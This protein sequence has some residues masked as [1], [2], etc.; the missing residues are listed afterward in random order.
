MKRVLLIILVFA[1][2]V[3][4]LGLLVACDDAPDEPA[5]PPADAPPPADVVADDLYIAILSKGFQ[6]QFWQAVYQGAQDAAAHYGVSIFF[7]GPE[8]EADIH[9]QVE[10]FNQQLALNPDG[11][12]LAALATDS[13]EAQL[14]DAFD[15]GI[16]VVGFDSGVPDA[17]PGQ[18]LATASTNNINA[19]AIGAD[20][21]FPEI[22]AQLAAATT[23]SPALIIILSQDVTSE[24][25]T[26]RTR[27]F[28]ERMYTLAG[29]VNSSVAITGGYGAINTGDAN[30][31]VQ[32]QVVVGASPSTV[33]MTTAATGALG[34][35]GLV[36][37]FGSN[38][39]AANAIINAFNAGAAIP[40][41]VPVV[42]FDAGTLQKDAVRAGL[43]FG[44]ITQ[45]PVQIGYQAVSLVVRAIR[46]ESISD[47][48]TGAQW[49]DASNMDDP[50]IAILLYD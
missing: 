16:P 17:P 50:A 41:G 24:S 4:S 30:A 49:W 20:H 38:D 5:S 23:D 10:M 15:R 32:I 13:V 29:E 6:H 28:A 46:G 19:A 47:V 40:D 34:T 2:A 36:G 14:Q 31:A 25:I 22:E 33:D 27:G 7:D 1:L 3:T 26:G 21:M 43:F 37:F 9:V 11:I 45:D 35:P 39:G 8:S 12:A 44:A 48:D 18:V 42:G